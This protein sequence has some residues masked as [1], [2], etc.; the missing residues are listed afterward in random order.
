[1]GRQHKA[2]QQVGTAALCDHIKGINRTVSGAGTLLVQIS[3]AMQNLAS[4]MEGIINDVDADIEALTNEIAA[5][6]VSTP[7]GTH[8]KEQ[9]GT[10]AGAEIYAARTL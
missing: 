3:T 8:S 6:E 4:E 1:M 9:I 5:G 10:R 2:L 7:L